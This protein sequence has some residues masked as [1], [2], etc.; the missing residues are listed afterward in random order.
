MKKLIYATAFTLTM[1]NAAFSTVV[2][3]QSQESPNTNIQQQSSSNSSVCN[4]VP[5]ARPTGGATSTRLQV[6]QQCYKNTPRGTIQSAAEVCDLPPA[7]PTGGAT[8]TRLQVF[9][10]C[11]RKMSQGSK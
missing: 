10:E 1:F 5:S 3:A 2:Y 8:V 11:Y 7:R 6:L 4:S 9:E